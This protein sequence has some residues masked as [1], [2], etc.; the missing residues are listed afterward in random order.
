M[1]DNSGRIKG[2]VSIVDIVL[3]VAILVL[4]AGFVYRQTSDRI[5][6]ILRPDTPILVTVQGDGLRHFITE[7]VSIGDVFYRQHERT[8]IGTVVDIH[9]EPAMDYL[10]RSDG[11]AVLA[12]SEGRYRIL[13]TLEATG[14]VVYGRGYF[15][16]GLDHLAPGGEIALI[17]NRVFIPRGQ[18][19]SV[20][21]A[22]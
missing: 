4:V 7:S 8:A 5:G 3:V 21:Q 6:Q 20:R 13:I 12:V 22:D 2:R 10:H 9:I 18:I 14:S 16:N 15:I 17:S 19:Y 11:T 1:I